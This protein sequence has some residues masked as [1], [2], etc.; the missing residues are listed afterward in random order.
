[1]APWKRTYRNID[2]IV[3]VVTNDSDSNDDMFMGEED[4][5]SESNWEY[6]EEP[7]QAPQNSGT[8]SDPLDQTMTRQW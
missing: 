1:M 8:V 3:D 6:E 4:D 7:K 2:E 5:E